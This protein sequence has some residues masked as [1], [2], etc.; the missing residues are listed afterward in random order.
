MDRYI[1]LVISFFFSTAAIAETSTAVIYPK[2]SGFTNN[3]F[4][5]PAVN[6][7]QNY[8]VKTGF[9][10]QTPDVGSLAMTSRMSS[11]EGAKLASA[12]TG[13]APV[14]HAA[15]RV[16]GANLLR[17][18]A[19]GALAVLG[20][21]A[22]EKGFEYIGSTW[23][24]AVPN[25]SKPSTYGQYLHNN[26]NYYYGYVPNLSTGNGCMATGGIS[27]GWSIATGFPG[28]SPGICLKYGSETVNL[29]PSNLTAATQ[30]DFDNLASTGR[31]FSDAEL[32]AMVD[33][34]FAVPTQ[35]PVATV[36]G[37]FSTVAAADLAWLQNAGYFTKGDAT[38]L[39]YAPPHFDERTNQW[40][41]PTLSVTAVPNAGVQATLYDKVIEPPV[42]NPDGTYTTTQ[43]T[44]PVTNQP[45]TQETKQDPCALNPNSVGCAKLDQPAGEQAPQPTNVAISNNPIPWGGDGACPVD[46]HIDLLGSDIPISYA[47]IC[48]YMSAMR[49]VVI[50][51]AWI[52]ATLILIG[53]KRGNE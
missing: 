14:N 19:V 43:K 38:H 48:Q 18:S 42:Q 50:G 25:P 6:L 26:G 31:N 46:V 9:F 11:A 36:V 20:P 10:W 52:T 34:G 35:K 30:S 8:G 13:V 47:P 33:A 24:V 3:A 28:Y 37:D 17:L 51:L 23:K 32:Q 2:F 40:V 4:T 39:D 53:S 44:D 1:A 41:Q 12:I 29:Y 15:A 49:P 45:L 7:V 16:L 5:K 21:W 22:L 27:N